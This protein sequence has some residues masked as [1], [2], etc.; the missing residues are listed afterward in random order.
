MLYIQCHTHHTR[1]THIHTQ[2]THTYTHNTH[3]YTHN[4]HTYTH[5]T[6]TYTHTTHTYTH[7]THIHTTHT[8][9]HTTHTYTHN[10]HIHTQH[11]HIHTQHT[12][13]HTT[14]THTHTHIHTHHTTPPPP[15]THTHAHTHKLTRLQMLRE[16]TYNE[17]STIQNGN[18]FLTCTYIIIIIH[19][20]AA[21]IINGVS[22]SEPLLGVVAICIK[23]SM[24]VSSTVP[25]LFFSG[26]THSIFIGAPGNYYSV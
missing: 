14:H 13:T 6:H 18:L 12:H 25:R 11:T 24:S 23:I 3:T 5:N 20:E 2:H 9:T 1:H 4:T 26:Q 7:N 8:H 17:S 10:T 15:H 21:M 16:S 22:L 19:Y